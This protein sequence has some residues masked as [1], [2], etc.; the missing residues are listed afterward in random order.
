MNCTH[1]RVT[2]RDLRS[3]EILEK[4]SKTVIFMSFESFR[5][6]LPTVGQTSFIDKLIADL[7]KKF[8]SSP[9]IQKLKRG[10][11]EIGESLN[12]T[13]ENIDSVYLPFSPDAAPEI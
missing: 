13:N 6:L 1:P 7:R 12:Q 4:R 8:Y 11:S 9:G 5:Q 2:G 3:H 10:S